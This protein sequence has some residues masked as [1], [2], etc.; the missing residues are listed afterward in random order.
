MACGLAHG[1][2]GSKPRPSPVATRGEV[3]KEDNQAGDGSGP[4]LLDGR[5]APYAARPSGGRHS[6]MRRVLFVDHV[7][8]ILGG[9]EVNLVELLADAGSR[10]AWD[11]T[12]ACS[13]ASPLD[14]RLAGLGVRR[15]PYE[16]GPAV[17]ELRVVG[18]PFP[19]LGA[20]RGLRALRAAG[21]RLRAI[22]RDTAPE[23]AVSC[24]N[25]DHFAGTAACRGSR[26]RSVWWVNDIVSAD[27]F[28]APARRALAWRARRGAARLAAVSEVAR[29]ALLDEGLPPKLVTTVYNGIPLDRYARRERGALRRL[30]GAGDD[31]FLAGIVGRFTPW[32]GQDVVI[33]VARR[34][35]EAGR[36]GRFLLIGKA[37]NEDAPFEA[38][39]RDAARGLEGVVHFVPFQPDISE[40]LSDLDVLVHASVKPEP[41]G[42]VVI[43]A[44]AVGVP[45]VAAR[46]GGVPEIITDGWDGL[47]VPPGDE[48]AY[49]A[50][51]GPL[52]DSP[53]RRA[54]LGAA[55]RRTVQERFTVARVQRDFERLFAE[56]AS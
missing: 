15:L 1:G 5:A 51:L 35:R 53:A 42:R 3:R 22:L 28:P 55:G 14:E 20:V 16:F 23:V 32:K 52:A 12:V 25:K 54:E 39:L 10:Q 43:E 50:A 11:V 24:T 18:R 40:A 36:K 41:F 45:A 34:W 56:V 13:P 44:M 21:R 30:I 48:A 31:E 38:A 2:A 9:A 19:L 49:A 17:N 4:S 6:L 8:R 37:F 47:L 29:R 26:T 33:R 7:N 27:F 46:A